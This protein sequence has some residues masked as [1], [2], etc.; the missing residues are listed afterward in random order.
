MD[1]TINEAVDKYK[2]TSANQEELLREIFSTV[3]YLDAI[4][5]RLKQDPIGKSILKKIESE[6]EMDF[7][8]NKQIAIEAAG[9]RIFYLTFQSTLGFK[10]KYAEIYAM[11]RKEAEE[12]AE[13]EYTGLWKEVHEKIDIIVERG[14]VLL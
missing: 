14:L 13:L 3:R 8:I 7:G 2:V 9:K 11:S 12:Q 6:I 10:D 5:T 4:I 1:I